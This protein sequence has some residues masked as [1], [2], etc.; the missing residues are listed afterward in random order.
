MEMTKQNKKTAQASNQ[1]YEQIGTCPAGKFLG[2]RRLVL[3]PYW[4]K[5]E[6]LQRNLQFKN[7]A[8]DNTS[9]KYVS[10]PDGISSP[11][12]STPEIS[13]SGQTPSIFETGQDFDI[14]PANGG[15]DTSYPLSLGNG[16]QSLP[17]GS[18]DRVIPDI[19]TPTPVADFFSSPPNGRLAGQDYTFSDEFT[20][21]RRR[22][23][24][25]RRRVINE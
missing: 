20:I 18:T 24:Q 3:N 12:L 10:V 4:Q 25:R 14:L 2:P 1:A 17:D 11:D 9:E 5:L 7:P 15:S 13:S 16:L 21:E 19:S 6:F 8:D 23:Q 22:K